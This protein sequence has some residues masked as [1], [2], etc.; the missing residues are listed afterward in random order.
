MISTQEFCERCVDSLE[1]GKM[2]QKHH[3]RDTENTETA[4][5]K[6]ERPSH[7]GSHKRTHSRS[8]LA[9]Q[10]K[11]IEHLAQVCLNRRIENRYAE[12]YCYVVSRIKRNGRF[13]L[14]TRI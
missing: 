4:Q 7:E 13:H 10:S 12:N 6:D 5:R 1:A 11:F 8:Y 14:N 3:H 2:G 9:R